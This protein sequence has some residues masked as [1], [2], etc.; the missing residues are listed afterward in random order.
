MS[1]ESK[2]LTP[3]IVEKDYWRSNDQFAD[4]FNAVLF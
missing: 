2:E 1:K 3:D 4:L